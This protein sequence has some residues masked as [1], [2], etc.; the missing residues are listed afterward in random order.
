LGVSGG[1]YRWT[2]HVE[3]DFIC[4]RSTKSEERYTHIFAT[5]LD[6]KKY[7]VDHQEEKYKGR[8][9]EEL[10]SFTVPSTPV[11]DK[12]AGI[13]VED[14]APAPE[15][16]PVEVGIIWPAG[17]GRGGIGVR[18]LGFRGFGAGCG[19]GILFGW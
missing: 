17:V 12:K 7:L 9:G 19:S 4:R 5:P 2:C 8:F 16:E 3:R 6:Y 13:A 11:A 10:G 18:G 15:G 1:Y 14:P